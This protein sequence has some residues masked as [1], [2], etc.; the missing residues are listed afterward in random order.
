MQL[1]HPQALPWEYPLGFVM[2]SCEWSKKT[3]IQSVCENQNNSGAA[4]TQ[5]L[6]GFMEIISPLMMLRSEDVLENLLLAR[7]MSNSYASPQLMDRSAVFSVVVAT[8]VQAC[9]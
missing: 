9:P 5:D 6:S 7:L 2:C 4:L 1:Q 8:P 3:V